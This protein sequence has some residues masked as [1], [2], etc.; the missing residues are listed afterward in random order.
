MEAEGQST[1]GLSLAPR[2]AGL[3]QFG[4]ADAE[5]VPL[6]TLVL[7]A[8]QICLPRVVGAQAPGPLQPRPTGGGV[9]ALLA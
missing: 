3:G 6:S 5:G 8:R 4:R 7:Q 9:P 2:I 1:G